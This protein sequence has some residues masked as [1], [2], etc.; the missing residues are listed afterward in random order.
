MRRETFI[1]F[2]FAFVGFILSLSILSLSYTGANDWSFRIG[3]KDADEHQDSYNF[4][5]ASENA[6]FYYD[7]KD[8]LEPPSSPLGPS[9]CLYFPH[10]DWPYQPGRYAS[11]VR[12]PISTNEIFEFVVEASEDKELTLFWS[13]MEKVPKNYRLLLVDDE[14][15][16]FIDMRDVKEY[17]FY[18]RSGLKHGFKIVIKDKSYNGS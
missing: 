9:L 10:F 3:V 15:E 12:P 1:G 14:R 17:G 11:D 5:V 7:S 4:I 18:S 2:I 8:W 13:N 16:I 6:S